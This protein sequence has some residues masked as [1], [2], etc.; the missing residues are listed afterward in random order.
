MGANATVEAGCE[1]I[2][3]PK[4]LGRSMV[5]P[6]QTAQGPVCETREA[7]E[8][9]RAFVSPSAKVAADVRIR[10]GCHIGRGT[11]VEQGVTRETGAQIESGAPVRA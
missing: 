4:P 3:G 5:P 11:T 2:A 8:P 9:Q 1:V 6:G 10:A 7:D